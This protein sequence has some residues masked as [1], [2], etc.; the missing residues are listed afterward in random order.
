MCISK[1]PIGVLNDE[2][3]I[4]LIEKDYIK[5]FELIKEDKCRY[6]YIDGSSLDLHISSNIKRLDNTE[7]LDEENKVSDIFEKAKSYDIN[8]ELRIKWNLFNQIKRK[9][10]FFEILR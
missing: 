7:K 9:N 5:N 10:R 4:V 8:Q 3:L 1:S 6:K 2:Q